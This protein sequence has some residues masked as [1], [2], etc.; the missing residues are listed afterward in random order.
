MDCTPIKRLRLKEAFANQ[1][2]FSVVTCDEDYVNELF[3]C[4]KRGLIYIYDDA[5]KGH[6]VFVRNT[7][8][9][10]TEKTFTA[11][12][13]RH[14]DLF[15]WHIDGVLYPKNSKC[16]CAIISDAYM[17]FV[18]FKTNAEN[19]TAEAIRENYDK[20]KNQ[21]LLT[22]KDVESRC[23]IAGLD[24]RKATEIE[25]F[26]VFNRTVPRNNAYQKKISAE[27]LEATEGIPLYFEDSKTID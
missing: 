24:L 14:T 18:E 16:D 5:E 25:A 27:F 13:P 26:A 9:L 21:L 20:A 22:F 3:E 17:A 6:S 12:N 2:K 4:T 11:V 10:G 8:G 15:L 1:Q 23:A 7:N 19:N